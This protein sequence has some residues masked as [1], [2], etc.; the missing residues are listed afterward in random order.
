MTNSMVDRT[1]QRF[2]SPCGLSRL[3]KLGV[4]RAQ[5][6][7]TKPLAP[8]DVSRLIMLNRDPLTLTSFIDVVVSNRKLAAFFA[9][10]PV[11]LVSLSRMS[12]SR[13]LKN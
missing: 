9:S 4:E 13:T 7:R 10:L 6:N 2:N 11:S 1:N 12:P 3:L 5:L 8:V